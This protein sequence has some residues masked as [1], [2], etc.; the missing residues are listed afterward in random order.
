MK[1]EILLA[2][3]MMLLAFS[4]FAASG[5]TVEEAKELMND[6]FYKE[7]AE[8]LTA[9]ADNETKNT[10]LNHLA[11]VALQRSGKSAEAK[12][13]LKRGT[14][15]SNI[16]LAEIALMNYNIEEAEGLLDQYETTLR[17]G[18]KNVE[19]PSTVSALRDE[20]EKVQSMLDRVEKIV[21]I[22]SIA[23]DKEEF[24]KA[25]KL[26]QSAGS[27]Q[28]EEGVPEGAEY[29]YPVVVYVTENGRHKI[30]AA[31]D[32]NED[33]VLV[34]S[35]LLD[36]GKWST[37]EELG[38]NLGEGGDA[39]FPFLLNDGETLYF[40]NDGEN[41][42]GGLD[43]FI[44]RRDEDGFL[45]PQNIGMPYNS[46]YDDYMLVIDEETGCGWWATDRNQLEDQ[47]T[48]Y[49]FIPSELRNN[50]PSDT[51]N[52]EDKALG[53]NYRSTWEDGKDYTAILRQMDA[54][55]VKPT[56]KQTEFILGLPDGRIYTSQRDF[57]NPSSRGLMKEYL[58]LENRLQQS[59]R[60]VA[61]LR[62]EYRKGRQGV[63]K[64]IETS[65]S[66]LEAMRAQLRNLKNDIVRSEK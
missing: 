11:G 22:D 34:E 48:I 59:E 17:K 62:K 2:I 3:G 58:D 14:N 61:E 57:K 37:P 20:I 64:E 40:A 49:R 55:T 65:E 16:N 18:K 46:P 25:Y 26:A 32:E 1:K 6:G 13:Y 66:D 47:V 60:R 12:K 63:A 54:K 50:Y 28:G 35:T 53:R 27:L 42:L 5:Q 23:V 51:E 4:R 24:F 52:L 31:P 10:S 30:W 41:S 38:E 39:N 56:E 21:I 33:Y 45:Q 9:A 7:A 29:A 19:I 44:T 36:D 15:E 8:I 43:I